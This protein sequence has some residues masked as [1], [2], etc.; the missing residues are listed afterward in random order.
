MSLYDVWTAKAELQDSKMPELSLRKRS[1]EVTENATMPPPSIQVTT[2]ATTQ[3]APATTKTA[4]RASGPL[5]GQE[6]PGTSASTSMSSNDRRPN[7]R[8]TESTIRRDNE[9][10][11]LLKGEFAIV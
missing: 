6:A 8:R 1:A 5:T 2:T 7:W 4:A 3:T 10:F 9:E 11:E